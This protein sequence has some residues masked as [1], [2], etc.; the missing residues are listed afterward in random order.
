M[1]CIEG[2]EPLAD[3]IPAAATNKNSTPLQ[4]AFMRELLMNQEPKSYVSHCQVI[5]DAK[6]PNLASIKMPVLII[7][8]EEDMSAPL[9]GCECLLDNMGSAR[10]ELKFLEGVGHWHCIEAPDRVAAEIDAFCGA[11]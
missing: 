7:A 1:K 6:E 9:E 11:L 10:K 4:K 8:G 2:M 3:T 5:I